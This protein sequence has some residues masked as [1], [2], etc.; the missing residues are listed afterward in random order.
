MNIE[1]A[2]K[3]LIE[4]GYQVSGPPNDSCW[5]ILPGDGYAIIACDE[6]AVESLGKVITVSD[7]TGIY[8]DYDFYSSKA[9]INKNVKEVSIY[10]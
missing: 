6:P 2:V 5:D 8:E 9:L 7:V 3:L 10:D 4:A 1:Q